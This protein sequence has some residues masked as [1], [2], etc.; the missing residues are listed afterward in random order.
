MISV[1]LCGMEKNSSEQQ[2]AFPTTFDNFLLLPIDLHV[3]ILTHLINGYSS[4]D[5]NFCLPKCANESE[6]AQRVRPFLL[7]N[8]TLSKQITPRILPSIGKVHILAAFRLCTAQSSVIFEEFIRSI[9]FGNEEYLQFMLFAEVPKC[10]PSQLK[11][12]LKCGADINIG[13]LANIN[14]GILTYTKTV[15]PFLRTVRMNPELPR[16]QFLLN[17]GANI[18]AVDSSGYNALQYTCLFADKNDNAYEVAKFLIDRGIKVDRMWLRQRVNSEGIYKKVLD[19][20]EPYG[21]PP[22]FSKRCIVS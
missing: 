3:V 10:E 21:P 9:Q 12:L 17:Q 2:K 8:K 19:L 13:M 16:L 6:A 18:Q 22:K 7:T 20:V 15:A 1:P 14:D 5:P 11:V 4:S